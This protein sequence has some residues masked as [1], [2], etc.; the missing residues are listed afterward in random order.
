MHIIDIRSNEEL[1]VLTDLTP[2]IQLVYSST[3]FKSLATG[4]YVSKALA[5][6]GENAC[7]QTCQSHLGQL[8]MLGSRSIVLFAIQTWSNRIDDFI[9]DNSL[10]LALN[11]A[12]SM[13]V[14][15][16]MHSKF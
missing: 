13:Y 7:Y 2:T 11:L 1:Q 10:D 3:F 8:F 9:N 6:A 15:L 5:Y 12:V 4:G 14:I 16:F